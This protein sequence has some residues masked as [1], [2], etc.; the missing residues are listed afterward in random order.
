MCFTIVLL[1]NEQDRSALRGWQWWR[2]PIIQVTRDHP[3]EQL[4][5]C[6]DLFNRLAAVRALRM[7]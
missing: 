3:F 7:C 1:G 5:D 4:N 6:D 2:L